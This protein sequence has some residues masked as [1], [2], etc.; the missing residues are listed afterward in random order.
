MHI[1]THV[2]L[3]IHVGRIEMKNPCLI[4][5]FLDCC[6]E[7]T[8]TTRG[9]IHAPKSESP[10]SKLVQKFFLYACQRNGEAY[11]GS[12]EYGSA[13]IFESKIFRWTVTE[14][15]LFSCMHEDELR[16]RVDSLLPI[17]AKIVCT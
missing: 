8:Y 3:C 5:A 6:R 12:G 13:F 15:T 2:V 14:F 10:H 4:T 16:T 7:Y 17:R 1:T 11:E 9:G